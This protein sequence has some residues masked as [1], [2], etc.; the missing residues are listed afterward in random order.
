MQSTFAMLNWA[1]RETV[2][3][4]LF[5]VEMLP[6]PGF[7]G[8]SYAILAAVY[9]VSIMFPS[10][11]TAMSLTGATAAVFV[12]YILP[13]ALILRVERRSGATRALGALCIALGALMGVVGV[14]NTLVL[15]A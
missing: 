4:E 5:G 10:V 7:F 2:S 14:A 6:G 9:A 12:A 1:L 3:K 15:S 13:G 11:W 8:V